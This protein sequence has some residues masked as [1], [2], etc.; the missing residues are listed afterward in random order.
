LRA[1][2]AGGARRVRARLPR[3]ADAAGLMAR[4]I[5]AVHE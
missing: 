5:E 3:W 2:L 1:R 4:T